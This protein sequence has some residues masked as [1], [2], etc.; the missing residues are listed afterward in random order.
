MKKETN[1]Y[2]EHCKFHA[3]EYSF[4]RAMICRN[5]YCMKKVVYIHL[6]FYFFVVSSFAK[7]I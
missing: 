3:F 1:Y 7:I 4:T 2:S 5:C 6:V